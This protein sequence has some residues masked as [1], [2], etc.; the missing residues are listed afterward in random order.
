DMAQK[1]LDAQDRQIE[2]AASVSDFM[3]SKFTS[4]QLYEWMSGQI[5]SVY[6]QTYQKAFDLAKAAERALQFELALPD[7][8]Y[9]TFGNWD[10]AR[11][12]LFA[13]EKLEYDLRRLE[14]VYLDEDARE[15]EIT[16][17]VSL[18][19]WFPENLFEL[20]ANGETTIDLQES[21]FDFDY[22]T[23]YLRR[24]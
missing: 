18:A 19:E 3:K 2:Q 22:P 5:S 12:G 14:A 6:Y 23:H 24:L 8:Q 9:V 15:Y 4:Q 16:K 10:N 13:A 21:L 7:A 11:Q 1:E 20:I 17:H